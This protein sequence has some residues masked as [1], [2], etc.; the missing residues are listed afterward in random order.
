MFRSVTICILVRNPI[1]NSIPSRSTQQTMV[2]G[3]TELALL[4]VFLPALGT[5]VQDHLSP[6]LRVAMET[7]LV[8]PKYVT[9][10]MNEWT[11]MPSG[12]NVF[13]IK[14]Y[15]LSFL[16]KEDEHIIVNPWSSSANVIDGSRSPMRAAHSEK[17]ASHFNTLKKLVLPVL[18]P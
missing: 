16:H 8:C 10:R 11:N 2:T 15:F 4:L 12:R 5:C 14:A 9:A 1:V 3:A 18:R 7:I 17:Q 6:F 13:K